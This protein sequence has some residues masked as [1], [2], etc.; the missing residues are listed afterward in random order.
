MQQH[1]LTI[2]HT[3]AHDDNNIYHLILTNTA[4][5]FEEN[6]RLV[7]ENFHVW[8]SIQDYCPIKTFEYAAPF[9]NLPMDCMAAF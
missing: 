1:Y 9:Q 7:L 3:F 6:S 5:D 2:T 8:L 4:Q